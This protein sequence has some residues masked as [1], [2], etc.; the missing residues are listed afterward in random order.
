M[1][2]FEYIIT[3]DLDRDGEIVE[4]WLNNDLIAEVNN[5]HKVLEIDIYAKNGQLHL[6][7]DEFSNALSY[8]RSKLIDDSY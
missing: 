5:E 2:N 4:I 6:T 8:A 1:S 3:S 7:L